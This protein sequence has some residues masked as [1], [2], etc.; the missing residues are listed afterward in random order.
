MGTHYQSSICD[1]DCGH[2]HRSSETAE[3][4]AKMR[5]QAGELRRYMGPQEPLYV[6]Q[7]ETGMYVR[8]YHNNGM[9]V[10]G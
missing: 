7:H 1:R 4:C 10:G 5:I 3:R 6:P 8:E 2:K 9:R